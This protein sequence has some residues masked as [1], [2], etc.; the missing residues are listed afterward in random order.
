VNANVRGYVRS[1]RTSSRGAAEQVWVGV[2]IG[3]QGCRVA[4]VDESG[5]LLASGAS[6]IRSEHPSPGRHE[7][8]PEDWKAAV[9]AACREALSTMPRAMVG[10]I[11]VSGT[12]GTFVIGDRDGRALSPA[13]M[14]D[15][16]RGVDDHH[17]IADAWRDCGIRNG[18]QV[19]PTWA[20][21][22]LAWALRNVS[23]A[24][25]GRI[26]HVA[27]FI[28]SWLA[29]VPVPTDMSHAL[30]T[31]YDLVGRRW[32]SEAFDAAGLPTSVL[33][34]VVPAGTVVG[35]V[36]DTAAA[37]CGMPAAGAAIVSGMTDGCAAQIASGAMRVGQWN[38]SLGTTFVLKG[39]T[40]ELL[41]DPL[42][43]VYSH[44]HPDE[45]WLPG[46]ASNSGGGVLAT[47]FPGADL[48]AM[49]AAATAYLP[50]AVVRYPLSMRGERFPFVR[51]DAAPFV[52]G[53]PRDDAEAYAA[54][55]QGVAFVERLGLSYVQSLGAEVAGP[56]AFTGGATRSDQWTQ[57]R[58]D[59]LGRPARLT[60]HADGAFGMAVLAAA[61]PGSVTAAADRMVRTRKVIGPRPDWTERFLEPYRTMVD[62]LER[63]SYI[64]REFAT[65]ARAS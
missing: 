50:T 14:Y 7:Q 48:S 13:L 57:L 22:K 43:A 3:T 32:P 26:Y 64:D 11:A 36:S 4:V 46:G 38:S 42:G 12:S 20:L 5:R 63:R 44:A 40:R 41:R 34:P 59:V 49:D 16:E 56:V 31:G 62:E 23:A 25:S 2:D 24:A 35:Q 18:Y 61:A 1:Q 37:A 55:L 60:E 8:R 39:V 52:L 9:S 19:Q 28:G 10:A 30:K 54:L 65:F 51:T 21:P 6:P 47:N 58:V 29:G 45:G 27:D 33:P 15:D 53:R 17:A